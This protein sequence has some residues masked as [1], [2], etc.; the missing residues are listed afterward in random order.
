MLIGRPRIW[1]HAPECEAGLMPLDLLELSTQV[2]QMG[3]LLA[4]RR[5]DEQRRLRL[6][7]SMLADY[8]DRWE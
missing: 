6:L 3:E 5:L 8:C 4:E 1:R 2:R 7:D